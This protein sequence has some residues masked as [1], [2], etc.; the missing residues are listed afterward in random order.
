MF[1]ELERRFAQILEEGE[2]LREAF[3]QHQEETAA[4]MQLLA[5]QIHELRA[6]AEERQAAAGGLT[7]AERFAT[8]A[9]LQAAVAAGVNEPAVQQLLQLTAEVTE[10][11]RE[12][13][14][15][16]RAALDELRAGAAAA[17]SPVATHAIF[18]TAALRVR[19]E[20]RG[21]V[22]LPALVRFEHQDL[23]ADLVVFDG[24]G[25]PH[26]IKRAPRSDTPAAETYR[27]ARG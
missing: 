17:T 11:A 3:A 8:H 21:L 6:S 4:A 26:F 27:P 16:T 24:N 5:E 25:A 12:A 14:V 7:H 2:K 20:P 22:E 18:T 19:G 1:E 23:H 9:E 15:E 10:T 13:V